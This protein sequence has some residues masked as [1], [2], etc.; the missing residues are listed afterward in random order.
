MGH[1]WFLWVTVSF[2]LPASRDSPPPQPGAALI[3]SLRPLHV[4]PPCLPIGSELFGPF[5]PACIARCAELRAE[6]SRSGGGLWGG[7]GVL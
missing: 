4:T 3:A 6:P 5:L 1:Y 2:S 7:Y